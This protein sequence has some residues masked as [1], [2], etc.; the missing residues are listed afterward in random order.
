MN[1]KYNGFMQTGLNKA[2]V[3]DKAVVDK[4]LSNTV[5][6][7]SVQEL[8]PGPGKMPSASLNYGSS[9]VTAFTFNQ[10]ADLDRWVF[11]QGRGEEKIA[12]NRCFKGANGTGSVIDIDIYDFNTANWLRHDLASVS[13][14]FLQPLQDPGEYHPNGSTL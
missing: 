14:T 2:G 10:F 4:I 1:T 5:S 11:S 9:G 6:K 12:E 13:H 3:N 8:T 7:N